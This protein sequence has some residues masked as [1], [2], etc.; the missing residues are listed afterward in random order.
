MNE[1]LAWKKLAEEEIV[2]G[3]RTIIRR[4]FELSPALTD[5][6][7]IIKGEQIV[8]V[9]PITPE[10]NVVMVKQFRPGPEAVFIDLPGG[11]VEAGEDPFEA[12]AREL[13]EE[14]GYSGKLEYVCKSVPSSYS[15]AVWH[16]FV[17]TNCKQIQDAKA[18]PHEPLIPLEMTLPDFKQ[19]LKS[20][21][22]TAVA[23]A[24]LGLEY[25]KLL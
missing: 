15:T 23:T 7:D 24:Y 8:C 3:Y 14:T 17:A 20:G 4:K 11:G 12:M 6:F 10:G 19:H 22:I 1:E 13:L 18:D 5:D 9:L 21:K 2:V 16:N 25:L